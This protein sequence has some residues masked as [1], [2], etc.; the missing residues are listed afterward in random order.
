MTKHRLG[1]IASLALSTFA[2]TCYVGCGSDGGGSS[3]SPGLDV[4]PSVPSTD[5]GVP[6]TDSGIGSDSGT[7]TFSLS[8]TVVGL[9]GTGLVLKDKSGATLAVTPNGG[10]SQKATFP[11]KIPAGGAFA[12]TV[13]TQPSDPPQTCVVSGGSGTVVAADVESITVNCTDLFTVGGT[14]MGLGGK[15]LILENNGA[16]DSVKINA[17]GSFAFPKPL[18]P[19]AAYAVTVKQHPTANW[20]TCTIAAGDAGAAG[21]V[22]GSANITNITVDCTTNTYALSVNVTGLVETGTGAVL[23]NNLAND[24]PVATNGITTFST[25]VASGETY[26]ITTLTQPTN[27]WQTCAPV[28]GAAKM[29]GADTTVN[30]ACTTRT[31][32]VGG[33]LSGLQG[34]GLVLQNNLGD[35]LTLNGAAANGAFDFVTKVASGAPY[36]VTVKTQPSGVAGETC[37]VSSAAGSV[38]GADITTVSVTCATEKKVFV[39]STLYD[40]N[41][42]GLAGGDAKCQARATAAG[43]AGTYKAWLSDTTGSPSTRFTQSIRPYVLVNGTKLANDWADLVDG[44]V[45]AA[46]NITELNTAAPTG[47]T[48]CGGPSAVWTNTNLSGEHAMDGWSCSNWSTNASGGGITSQSSAVTLQWSCGRSP[49]CAALAALYCFQQ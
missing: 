4:G 26:G 10:A 37:S 1:A 33:T 46:V 27:P 16:A 5:A 38:A 32:E 9:K 3:E 20:Q 15:D 13:E 44:T 29:L 12:V 28:A 47:G 41:L 30:V 42:G 11:V 39:T 34:N 24:L 23:Q 49:G 40:G 25:K 45:L 43:L 36:A 7:K 21:G 22:I 19:G 2:T 8:A 17:N 6:A 14:V 31:F 48:A 35:D 18:P